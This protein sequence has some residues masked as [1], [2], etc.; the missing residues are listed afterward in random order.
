MKPV[1]MSNVV[2]LIASLAC[3][4]AVGKLPLTVTSGLP[5]SITV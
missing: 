3:N 4:A 5:V 1:W 2:L